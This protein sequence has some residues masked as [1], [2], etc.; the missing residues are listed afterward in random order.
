MILTPK[1]YTISEVTLG[2]PKRVGSIER[3]PRQLSE[4]EVG[5][6]W[7]SPATVQHLPKEVCPVIGVEVTQ[8]LYLQEK[9]ELTYIS[10]GFSSTNS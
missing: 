1:W 5:I 9:R 2:L 3:S 7:P 4:T 6:V 8:L 10:G